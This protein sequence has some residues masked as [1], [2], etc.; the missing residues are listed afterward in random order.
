MNKKRLTKKHYAVI[1]TALELSVADRSEEMQNL[2]WEIQ[3]I[4]EPKTTDK[5][6][7]KWHVSNHSWDCNNPQHPDYNS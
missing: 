4:I 7:T 3:D 6:I 1:F 2:I 5:L